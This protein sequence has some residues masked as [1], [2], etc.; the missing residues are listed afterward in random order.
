M[1]IRDRPKDAQIKLVEEAKIPEFMKD[2]ILENNN[3]EI[4]KEL[5]VTTFPEYVAAYVARCV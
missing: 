5:G 3:S 4:Y 1:C 2:S